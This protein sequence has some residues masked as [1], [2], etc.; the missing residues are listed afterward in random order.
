[1]N[2]R[3]TAPQDRVRRAIERKNLGSVD[4]FERLGPEGVVVQVWLAYQPRGKADLLWRW[5]KA[6]Q[7]IQ[8]LPG[9][10]SARDDRLFLH[11]RGFMDGVAVQVAFPFSKKRDPEMVE[12]VR[13]R[14]K[15]PAALVAGLRALDVK[16]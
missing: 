6:M 3:T 13:E 12:C 2:T 5:T 1:M 10:F 8:T 15:K 4:K 7:I 16:S 11:L 14:A 9:E